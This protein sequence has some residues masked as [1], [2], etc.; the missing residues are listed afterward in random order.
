MINISPLSGTHH[1]L[2]KIRNPW[3]RVRAGGEW[4]G[5]WGDA[6]EEAWALV[7]EGVL[8]SAGVERPILF[9]TENQ[10]EVS[11]VDGLHASLDGVFFMSWEDFCEHAVSLSVC[12]RPLGARY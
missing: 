7:G 4:N 6:D 8:E 10:G 2:L 3:G 11:K 1:K 5:R 12:P 9:T